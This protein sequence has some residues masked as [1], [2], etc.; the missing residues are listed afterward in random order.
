MLCGLKALQKMDLLKKITNMLSS[1][2]LIL[3]NTHEPSKM[4]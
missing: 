4:R 2:A 3:Q 1:H